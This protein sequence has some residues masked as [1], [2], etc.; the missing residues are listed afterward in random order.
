LAGEGW[1]WATD[2]GV[3]NPL[4]GDPVGKAMVSNGD[5]TG[6]A[7]LKIGILYDSLA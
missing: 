5:S 3:T 2:T 6:A 4:A 7:T 1:T